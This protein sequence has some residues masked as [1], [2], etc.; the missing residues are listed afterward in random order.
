MIFEQAGI[1]TSAQAGRLLGRAAV[2]T[3]LERRRWR[4][5]CRGILSTQNGVLTQAQQLSVAV[6][7]AGPGARLAGSTA[8]SE[9][10]VR[11]LRTGVIQ[12]TIPAARERSRRLPRLPTDVPPVHIY[13]TAVLPPEH[14]QVGRPPRTTVA[15]SVIDAA[16]WAGSDDEALTIITAACQQR[17]V[18]PDELREV[19]TL[20]PRIHRHRLIATTIGDVEG[21]SDALSEIDFIRL[22]R[23]YRLP[24]P[25]QQRRRT[26]TD[27]RVRFVDAY[28][29]RSRV[30]VEVDGAHHMD[31]R[32]W[33]ADML[34]QNQIWL[35]GDRILRFPAWLVRRDPAAVAAQLR[36]ALDPA[37]RP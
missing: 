29:P 1:L 13:R 33:A 11:G 4:T 20:F 14:Q 6:M 25:D 8:A 12:V 37:T 9:S 26:D 31:V 10:G 24:Q 21:G 27:G 22:C 7:V 28:W 34:R 36:T 30:Q 32:H 5:I 35:D 2:R 16:G 17:R 15:R 19:L 18:Q 23:R 3:S